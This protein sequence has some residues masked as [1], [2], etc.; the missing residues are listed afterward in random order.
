ME[1]WSMVTS[2]WNPVRA[3]EISM[4][5]IGLASRTLLT[6][7]HHHVAESD[8][9]KRHIRINKE[10][11]KECII[12]DENVSGTSRM[13]MAKRARGTKVV[14]FRLERSVT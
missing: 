13:T 4:D 12:V 14:M 2:R 9:V 7:R 3:T 6:Y 8:G 10:R 1:S 5:I 11:P